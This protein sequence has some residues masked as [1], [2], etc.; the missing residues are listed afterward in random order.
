M[1]PANGANEVNSAHSTVVTG[2]FR[3]SA[4]SCGA[5]FGLSSVMM[6]T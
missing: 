5:S 2:T 6:T 1:S 3:S 4:G